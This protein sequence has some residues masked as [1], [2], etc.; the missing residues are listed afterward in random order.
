MQGRQD[1]KTTNATQSNQKSPSGTQDAPSALQIPCKIAADNLRRTDA[2]TAKS[3][4][5][6]NRRRAP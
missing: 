6:G 2:D 1:I 5:D 4:Q 3:L